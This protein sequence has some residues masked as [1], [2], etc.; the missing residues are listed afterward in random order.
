MWQ[1]A[2][3]ETCPLWWTPGPTRYFNHAGILFSEH[4]SSSELAFN[5]LTVSQLVG[6][7]LQLCGLLRADLV[8][9]M[10]GSVAS[11]MHGSVLQ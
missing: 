5:F 3:R 6:A 7:A 11:E 2:A 10:Q 1:E 8:S 9:G 4:Y